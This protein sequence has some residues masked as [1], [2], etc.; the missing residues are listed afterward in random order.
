MTSDRLGIDST[1][2]PDNVV[3]PQ[4]ERTSCDR[5]ATNNSLLWHVFSE[6]VSLWCLRN[7]ALRA[8]EALRDAGVINGALCR[9]LTRAQSARSRI[10]HGYV[11]VPAGDV[12]RA[13]TLVHDAA[14]DFIG[15]YRAWIGSY[16]S[17]REAGGA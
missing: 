3:T 8:L 11:D 10:E 1:Q 14:R 9:R 17:G 2:R 15:R 13:A 7:I 12:H 5:D 16:L 6:T 4:L